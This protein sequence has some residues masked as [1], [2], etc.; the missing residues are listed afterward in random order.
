[1]NGHAFLTRRLTMVNSDP[2]PDLS[3][4]QLRAVLAVAEYRSFIAASSLLGISQPALTRTIQQVELSLGVALFSRTTR[5]VEVTPAGREFAALAERLLNDMRIGIGSMR[6]HATH[7]SGQIIVTSV[8]S[9]SDAVLPE[10]LAA[11]RRRYPGI[12]LHL[13]EGIQRAVVDDV[14]SGVA[15]FGIG[16]LEGLPETLVQE[17]LGAERFHVVLPSAHPLARRKR[18]EISALRDATLV[19]FPRESRSRQIADG[20]A[21]AAGFILSYAMTVNRLS[22]LLSLVRNGIGLAIVPAC[23]R[24]VAAD[25]RLTSRPLLGSRCACRL[26]VMRAR[27]RELTPAAAILLVVVRRWLRKRT[28][29]A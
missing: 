28:S 24:P 7:Q 11:F 18:V 15:D 23:E 22:T 25:R 2:T 14:Q 26:G 10:S 1:M 21:A 4:R 16:F 5:Q 19:S 27:E 8:L 13:R 3:S 12:Q 9:L 17:D 20:A 29:D 6:A